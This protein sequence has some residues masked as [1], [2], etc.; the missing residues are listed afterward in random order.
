[1]FCIVRD[2][3]GLMPSAYTKPKYRRIESA[4]SRVLRAAC[5]KATTISYWKTRQELIAVKRNAD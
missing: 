1:M 4:E 5:T 3:F 2:R